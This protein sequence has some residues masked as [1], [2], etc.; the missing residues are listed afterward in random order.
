M[1]KLMS[2]VDVTSVNGAYRF[3]QYRDSNALPQIELYK[4]EGEKEITISNVLGEVKKLND[5]FKFQIEYAP[6]NRKST[7][8]TREFTEKFISL[9]RER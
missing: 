6:K 7:L 9:Y 8:N 2:T 1:K 3:Y 5:E 4:I